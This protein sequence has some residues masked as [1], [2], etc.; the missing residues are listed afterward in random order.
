MQG[1]WFDQCMYNRCPYICMYMYISHLLQLLRKRHIGNDIVTVIFQDP[2]CEPFS[3]RCIRSQFQHIFI[4]VRVEDPCTFATKY[5]YMS[6]LNLLIQYTCTCTSMYTYTHAC[7]VCKIFISIVEL[8]LQEARTFPTL[9][10]R[11]RTMQCLT[12]TQILR[13]SYSQNVCCYNVQCR[14]IDR[15][16][17]YM[18]Q[19][20]CHTCSIVR[21]FFH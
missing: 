20:S 10:L 18:Y 15:H 6:T 12:K 8:Q 3:P 14:E 11:S 9:D 13:S 16:S 5:R 19:Y 21:E 2:G 7:T 17:V 4:V 1:E